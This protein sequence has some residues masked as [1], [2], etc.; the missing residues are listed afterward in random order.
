MDR[1]TLEKLENYLTFFN[2]MYDAVRLVNPVEKSVVD[3]RGVRA[4]KLDEVCYHYWSDGRICDNCIS[5]R[6]YLGKNC[7]MKLEKSENAIMMVT[8]LPIENTEKP[9]VIE[10]LKNA[11]DTMMIG[12]GTYTDGN[13]MHNYIKELNEL[14]IKDELT[15]I[16]N[17]RYVD[18]R[19][20]TDVVRSIIKKKPLSVIFLDIDNL[21]EINDT[22][23]H[24]YGDRTIQQI[25]CVLSQ[26]IRAENDWVARYGGDELF[27]CLNNTPI[28]TARQISERIRLK[29]QELL[30]SDD[31]GIRTSVS[32][33]VHTMDDAPLTAQEL[34]AAA[35]EKMYQAKQQGKNRIV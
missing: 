7:F 31:K 32:M 34:I 8:A 17:R 12:T 22:Y 11:T 2:K 3:Y 13:M 23:G 21:K 9:T 15:G 5:V 27:V 25:A 33:G 28:Q 20:P 18:E 1:I 6:A 10:L 26:Y 16:Y 30:I 4:E 29:I 19:L 14:A 35:D 24:L